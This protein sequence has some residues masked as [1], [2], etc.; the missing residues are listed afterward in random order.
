[1][2]GARAGNGVGRRGRGLLGWAGLPLIATSFAPR[3]SFALVPYLTFFSTASEWLNLPN[4]T[5]GTQCG[6]NKV[7][8]TQRLGKTRH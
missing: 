6:V 1:M 8:T 2:R 3:V 5:Q 7:P 4:P